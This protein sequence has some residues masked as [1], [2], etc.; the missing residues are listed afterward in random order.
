MVRLTKEQLNNASSYN[1][2]LGFVQLENVEMEDLG[3]EKYDVIESYDYDGH[4]IKNFYRV[5]SSIFQSV[6]DEIANNPECSFVT[7]YNN[8]VKEGIVPEK[9]SV[10]IKDTHHHLEERVSSQ[11]LNYYGVA[12]PV[13]VSLVGDEIF[14]EDIKKLPNKENAIRFRNMTSGLTGYYAYTISMDFMSEGDSLETFA[15]DD[16]NVIFFTSIYDSIDRVRT[17]IQEVVGNKKLGK[18][19]KQKLATQL[20]DEYVMSLLVRKVICCDSDFNTNN[21]AI[22]SGKNPKII[23]FDFELSLGR[24]ANQGNSFE[25]MKEVKDKYPN[26]WDKFL[27]KSNDLYERMTNTDEKTIRRIL[28][29]P[30]IHKSLQANLKFVSD[31]AKV[32][33]GVRDSN[34]KLSM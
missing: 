24:S 21:I 28:K 4:T 9:V 26:V 16:E 23:N 6:F 1:N 7:P 30:Q 3:L 32:N 29:N 31:C 22:L 25:L 33:F 8:I 20:E 19:A 2:P 15:N 27:S 17:K 5:N 13:N 18:L 14:K 11:I 10:L 12:C 34:H